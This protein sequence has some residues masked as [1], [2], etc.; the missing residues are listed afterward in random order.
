M[1]QLPTFTPV[2]TASNRSDGWT[3]AR[4]RAFIVALS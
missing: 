1:T 2:P 3:P 4:Q